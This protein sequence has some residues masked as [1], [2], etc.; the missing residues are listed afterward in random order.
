M[1]IPSAE[2][3]VGNFIDCLSNLGIQIFSGDSL[4]ESDSGWY[5][6][7]SDIE[8]AYNKIS[9][10]EQELRAECV[11][12]IVVPNSFIGLFSPPEL[13]ELFYPCHAFSLETAS[14][15]LIDQYN[16]IIQQGEKSIVCKYLEKLKEK[17]GYILLQK[18]SKNSLCFTSTSFVFCSTAWWKFICVCS[19]LSVAIW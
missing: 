3:V 9:R 10:I 8:E 1:Q 6:E 19:W 12:D 18:P 17:R 13:F 11:T 4:D 16:Y 15:M 2:C 7:E 14:E 5:T